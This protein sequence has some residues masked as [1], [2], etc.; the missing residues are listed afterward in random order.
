MRLRKRGRNEYYAEPNCPGAGT[1][2]SSNE[3]LVPRGI[4]GFVGIVLLLVMF[5][6]SL[7]VVFSKCGIFHQQKGQA[8]HGI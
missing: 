6:S 3:H 1:D 4:W 8:E 2:W 5:S 7:L